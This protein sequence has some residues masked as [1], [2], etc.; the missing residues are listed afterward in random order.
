MSK[1]NYPIKYIRT[2]L[3]NYD[4]LAQGLWYETEGG[5]KRRANSYRAPFEAATIAK[6]DIDIAIDILGREE[7]ALIKAMYLVGHPIFELEGMF[8]NES[9]ARLEQRAV[10]NMFHYLNGECVLRRWCRENRLADNRGRILIPEYL[11]VD[12]DQYVKDICLN[13]CVV[14]ECPK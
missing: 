6:A 1:K 10:R 2:L 9:I 5:Q 13:Y 3:Q 7:K 12:I 14:E 11:P 4:T 8:P